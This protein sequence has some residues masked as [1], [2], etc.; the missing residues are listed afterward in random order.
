MKGR[1]LAVVGPTAAGKSELALRLAEATGGEIVLCDAY[2]I[3]AGLPILTAK[4]GPDELVRAPHHLV[5][6]LPLRQPAT[7][8]LF[9]HLADQVLADLAARGRAA[10][11]CGGTGLYLRALVRGLFPGP[12]A[13]PAFR[14]ALRQQAQRDGVAALHRRLR[15]L[16]PAAAAR[17]AESDYVR[18]ERALEVLH[19]TGRPISAHQADS[20]LAPPRYEVLRVA[21]DPGPEPLR[22]RIEQRARQMVE[23]G[24]IQEVAEAEQEGPVPHPPLG[25]ALVLRHLRGELD[26]EALVAALARATAQYARRQRTWFRREPQVHW[27]PH[28]DAVP[29]PDLV[30]WLRGRPG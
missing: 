2:Q 19:L 3:R 5:G 20:A 8:A 7:A 27:Y 6:V 24:V 21:L 26:R 9:V 29:L 25:H 11:L 14:A 15:T 10:I 1:L 30:R 17:I 12:G 13:D 28:P 23:R 18:I 16:D 22:R 4:P